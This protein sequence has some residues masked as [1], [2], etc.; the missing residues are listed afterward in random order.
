M[1]SRGGHM[2][3]RQYSEDDKAAALAALAA[4]GGNVL[5]TARELSIPHGTLRR[6]VDGEGVGAGVAQKR[7]KKTGELREELK[8]LA[9]AITGAMPGKIEA[10]DLRDAAVALGIVAD[11]Y[12]ALRGEPPPAE[13]QPPPADGDV[14][15]LTDEELTRREDER[16]GQARVG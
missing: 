8:A 12:L 6:W 4:N 11:K 16:D 9:V 5:R 10:A 1:R 13:A 7:K 15:P 2:V 14:L 3:K